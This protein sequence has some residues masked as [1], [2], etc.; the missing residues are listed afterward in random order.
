MKTVSK[1]SK[2]GFCPALVHV[3]R[4]K[5]IRDRKQHQELDG[6]THIKRKDRES[7]FPKESE[8]SNKLVQLADFLVEIRGKS[9]VFFHER[10]LTGIANDQKE[11]E[12]LRQTKT[13][14]ELGST[15]GEAA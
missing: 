1:I 3:C 11:E 5:N 2:Y 12:R 15:E 10:W 9:T 14:E 8:G 6:T 4:G 7:F 13:S